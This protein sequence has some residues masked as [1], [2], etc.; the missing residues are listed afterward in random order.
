M[1]PRGQAR[2]YLAEAA[3]PK[4]HEEVKIGQLHPVS[5]PIVVRLGYGVG[6]LFLRS[7]RPL[8]DLGSLER[9]STEASLVLVGRHR[10][11][12]GSCNARP[13]PIPGSSMANLRSQDQTLDSILG[14]CVSLG[15]L[16]SH[17]PPGCP[18]FL[19]AASGIHLPISTDT[20]WHHL[21]PGQPTSV[22]STPGFAR[23]QSDVLLPPPNE[24][25]HA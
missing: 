7:L 14:T 17:P 21:S 4:H 24:S 2:P 6:G 19:L 3:F 18:F 25:L 5:V 15:S 20:T 22:P 1:Q 9:G 16:M 23:S 11:S 13:A 12:C 10:N 8:T